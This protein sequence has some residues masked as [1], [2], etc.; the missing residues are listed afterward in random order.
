MKKLFV[1]MLTLSSAGYLPAQ[2]KFPADEIWKVPITSVAPVID[3]IM[4][5]VWFNAGEQICDNLDP[6]SIAPL[7]WF[8]FYVTARLL[9][10]WTNLY[11]WICVWDGVIF[12][13]HENGEWNYD[14]IDIY[15]D[16]DNQKTA[17]NYDG[18]DY[19]TWR[20]NYGDTV[21]DT[22]IHFGSKAG[23]GDPR[24]GTEF[25]VKDTDFG[26][27]YEIKIPLENL[28]L[29]G[30]FATKF[31]F[32]IQA[33]DSDMPRTRE[34]VYRWWACSMDES[35][36]ASL[37]GTAELTDRLISEVL[38]VNRISSAPV[39]DGIRDAV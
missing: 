24:P 3:G 1:L 28:K 39:I 22:D 34:T 13:G 12:K 8:D 21:G 31:G 6:G 27:N 35:N 15:F 33:N 18:V 10:D 9:Y 7:N 2:D 17:G 23:W 16:A 29:L 32:D 38:E 20:F 37:F 30:D 5:A 36:D 4:D 19:I 14:G 26:Y 25:A 11:I